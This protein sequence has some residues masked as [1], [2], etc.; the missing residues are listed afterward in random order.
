[1]RRLLIAFTILMA[2]GPA[3]AHAGE[4]HEGGWTFEPSV[5]L[6]LLTGLS[7]YLIGFVRLWNRSNAGRTALGQNGVKFMAGWAILA[8]ALI[9]PLH[10]GGERSFTLHMIEHELIMLP[11]AA[12]LALS[13]PLATMIWAL[14]AAAR[15]G[16]AGATRSS[17]VAKPWRLL[18]DPVAATFLQAVAL[19]LWHAPSTFNWA[20]ESEGWHIAQHL[21]FLVTALLFWWAMARPKTGRRGYGISAACLFATSLIG[22][23]LGAL[24]ALSTSPWYQA[25]AVMGMTP[26]GLTPAEDQQLAGLIMWIPGGIVHAGAALYCLYLWLQTGERRHVLVAE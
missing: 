23:A 25:Y 5:T 22:G 24:M 13:Q 12:L 7:I 3:L 8:G 18:T 15:H 21:S 19:W 20:L 4:A 1:M 26:E 9:S 16:V 14:P 10:E 2:S 6:P 11:A 17:A